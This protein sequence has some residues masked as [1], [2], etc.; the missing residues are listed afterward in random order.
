MPVAPGGYE[1]G[2]GEELNEMV[3][4]WFGVGD[5]LGVY[6][7]LTGRMPVAPPRWV[8]ACTHVSLLD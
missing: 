4:H 3:A 1:R 7:I 6:R 8:G 2:E 5:G